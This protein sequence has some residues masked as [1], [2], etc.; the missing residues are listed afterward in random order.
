MNNDHEDMNVSYSLLDLDLLSFKAGR[1][2][3]QSVGVLE[4]TDGIGCV[5]KSSMLPN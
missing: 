5:S 3:K 1:D 4:L 2:C